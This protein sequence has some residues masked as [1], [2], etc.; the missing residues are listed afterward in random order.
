M[1]HL[2]T[3]KIF[4]RKFTFKTENEG[5]NAKKIA[6]HFENEVAKVEKQIMTKSKAVDKRTILVLAGMNM[7]SEYYSLKKK[8]SELLDCLEKRSAAVISELDESL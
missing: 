2:V 3:L 1:N 7:A 8:H 4:G 6:A 5:A